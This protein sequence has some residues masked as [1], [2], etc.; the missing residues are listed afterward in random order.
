MCISEITVTRRPNFRFE[1]W[2]ACVEQSVRIFLVRSS[3]GEA[4]SWPSSKTQIRSDFDNFRI[5]DSLYLPL[6]LLRLR[7]KQPDPGGFELLNW[8]IGIEAQ[9]LGR[10]KAE[11]RQS[12][13]LQVSLTTLGGWC[14]T[15]NLNQLLMCFSKIKKLWISMLN[16]GDVSRLSRG[17]REKETQTPSDFDNYRDWCLSSARYHLSLWL[18]EEGKRMNL[19]LS[20]D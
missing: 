17:S 15:I 6:W 5:Q 9:L 3:R 20:N 19:N 18:F 4:E 2:G 7:E 12:E 1:V 13:K 11:S 8:S 16:C 10:F 14:W